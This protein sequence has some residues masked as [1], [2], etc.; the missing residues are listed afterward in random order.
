MIYYGIE[1][2]HSWAINPEGNRMIERFH[3]LLMNKFFN[4][5]RGTAADFPTTNFAKIPLEKTEFQS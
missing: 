5:K 1:P 3:R 4:P 2:Y